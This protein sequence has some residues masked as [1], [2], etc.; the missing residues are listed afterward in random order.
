MNRSMSGCLATGVVAA[1]GVAR[2]QSI[3]NLGAV[4]E[5]QSSHGF[6]IN[7]AGQV[8]GRSFGDGV[9]R[10]FR[11]DG[12]PGAA[13]VMRD[14]GSLGSH[15]AAA[16]VNRFGQVTGSSMLPSARIHAF[17]YDGTPGA[18]GTMRDL[19]TLGGI[20]SV[21][22]GIND[23]GQVVGSS[24]TPDSRSHAFKYDGT[25]GAG[26]I[27]RDLGTLAG[28]LDS[29][30]NAI[31][32][33]GQVVGWSHAATAA[34]PR[35]HAFR[36]DG[37]P[38]AGGVMRDLGVIGG[39]DDESFATA[40]NAGGQIAG[41]IR[42][43]STFHTRAFRYDG[44]PGAG[45]IMHDLGTLGGLTSESHAVNAK[46]QVAGMSLDAAGDWTAFVYLGTPGEG[47]GMHNL[48]AWLDARNPV[49][50]AKWRLS[51]AYGLT[52]EGWVTGFGTY[53]DGPGGLADGVRAFVLDAGS[54]TN[55]KANCD[56]STTAPVLNALDF[57]CFL[58]KFVR[59]SEDANCDGSDGSP[60]LT[61]TDFACFMMVYTAGCS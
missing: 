21:G 53:N 22:V 25:P 23:H 45:G 31:N 1:A 60:L 55:C 61:A 48:D 24:F 49:A 39:A 56:Y 51:W 42:D 57:L 58:N 34:G 8:A 35:R 33:A 38:G 47:G 9:D 41:F 18:G 19:G 2:G 36:Y 52:D 40:I 3:Y 13:A 6:G 16:A 29:Y 5:G 17:R 28:V 44:A 46:G 20:E 12:P 11:Y 59:N 27:M 10:A 43:V 54:L 37:T 7:S 26:G 15:S 32:N 4:H 50:G 14:L 30:A